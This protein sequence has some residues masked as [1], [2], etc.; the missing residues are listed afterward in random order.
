MDFQHTV[1]YTLDF[2]K[3]EPY[4]PNIE[5]KFPDSRLAYPDHN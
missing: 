4:S 2:Q 5:K 1:R 3:P